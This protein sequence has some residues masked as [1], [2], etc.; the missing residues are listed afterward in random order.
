M[1]TG[2]WLKNFDLSLFSWVVNRLMVFLDT[3]SF[4]ASRCLVMLGG[5]FLIRSSISIF[6]VRDGSFVWVAISLG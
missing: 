2:E 4:V 3:L 6:L 1:E 5:A